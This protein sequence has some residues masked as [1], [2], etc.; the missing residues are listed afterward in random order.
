MT[1]PQRL[2]DLA[3]DLAAALWLLLLLAL[4]A[5]RLGIKDS[6]FDRSTLLSR[7]IGSVLVLVAVVLVLF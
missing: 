6:V 4:L 3:E 5:H 2:E 7:V 1:A